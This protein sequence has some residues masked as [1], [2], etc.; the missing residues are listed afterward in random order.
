MQ[1][2]VWRGELVQ[3][4]G[5]PPWRTAP[6]RRDDNARAQ[7]RTLDAAGAA[8]GTCAAFNQPQPF[9]VFHHRATAR[10]FLAAANFLEVL[11][12]F[13]AT[14]TEVSNAHSA[15]RSVNLAQVEEKIKYA[16]WR[17]AEIAK[18]ERE[19]RAPVPPPSLSPVPNDTASVDTGTTLV[20]PPP[21]EFCSPP[22]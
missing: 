14:D 10:K 11:R 21:P 22:T 9:T 1:R 2:V 18:A 12:I 17:A 4:S 15:A 19:G 13:D 5:S 3:A 8:R 6:Q 16:K 20:S 7:Q